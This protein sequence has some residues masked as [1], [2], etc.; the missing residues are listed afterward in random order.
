[1]NKRKTPRLPLIKDLASLVK[2]LKKDIDD[3]YRID[4]DDDKPGMCLT[5]GWSNDGDW[6]Y[7]TG[8]NSFSGGA[9]FHPH[10][11]IVSIYRRSNSLEI[12]REIQSQLCDLYYQSV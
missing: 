8:D 1:M 5:I 4:E 12:A 3:D 6:N 10:W 11:A 7:Q 2:S 9:Y